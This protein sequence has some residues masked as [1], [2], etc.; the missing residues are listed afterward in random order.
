MNVSVRIKRAEDFSAESIKNSLLVR[1]LFMSLSHHRVRV[2][3]ERR[4]EAR[5]LDHAGAQLL[6]VD[7]RELGDAALGE[8]ALEGEEGGGRG[9]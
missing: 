2:H 5:D 6:F 1:G 9:G 7:V 4:A 3:E 8:E